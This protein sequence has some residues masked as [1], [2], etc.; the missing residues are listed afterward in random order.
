MA[1]HVLITGGAG[2]IGSNLAELLLSK[3]DKV[4]VVDNL[5]T[6]QMKN[7]QPFEKNKNFQF[8][9][10]DIC[11]WDE[12]KKAVQWADRIYHLAANIGQ[13]K[14]LANPL[15]TISNNIR[16]CEVI[17][18]A[19]HAT[20]SKA[21]ILISSTSELYYHSENDSEGRVKENAMIKFHSGKFRQEAYSLSKL[22]NEVMLLGYAHA[23]GI[24][25]VIARVFNTIGVNQ[26]ATYGMVVPSFIEQAL[27]NQ[28]L[29]VFGDGKQKRSFSDVRDTVQ[30][31]YLLLES[32]EAKGEVVNVGNDVE[33]SILDL[34]KLVKEITKSASEIKFLSYQEAYGVDE[35]EDVRRRRPN[36]HKLKS[37]TGF[38]PVYSLKETINEILSTLK[39]G[40]L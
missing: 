23:M 6:G 7:I 15:Q 22:V 29:T 8:S 28:P 34:A 21:K 26:C 35:F 18:D 3:G 37:L 40:L 2:F 12:L 39:G 31:L 9:N 10:A 30:A 25:C 17:L 19:M 27:A 33:C 13:K 16:G 20:K 14:V 32:P 11:E 5:Q 36:L 38:T 1:H 4:W 24:H